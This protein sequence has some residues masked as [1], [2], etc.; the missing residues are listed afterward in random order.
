MIMVAPGSRS[1]GLTTSV[2][3]DISYNH[4]LCG[5]L[6]VTVASAADQRT[7]LIISLII[8]LVERAYMAGKLKG[9]IAAQT[10]RGSRR[11]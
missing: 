1:E 2:F 4:E 10:P 8:V 11:E 6:P 3:P 7:I 9:V 5:Y